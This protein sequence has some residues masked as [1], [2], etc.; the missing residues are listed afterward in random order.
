[1]KALVISVDGCLSLMKV[2]VVRIPFAGVVFMIY[3][4]V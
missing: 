1:M 2:C 3:D 4:D